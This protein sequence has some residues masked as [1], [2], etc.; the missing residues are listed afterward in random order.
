ML[1]LNLRPIFNAKGIEKPSQFLVKN[2]FNSA[3]AHK[4]LNSKTRAIKLDHIEKLCEILFCE[5]TDLFQ[6][7]PENADAV[8][9]NNP[10]R[11]LIADKENPTNLRNTLINLPYKQLKEISAK[12]SAEIKDIQ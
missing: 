6:W 5:P 8:L 7:I 9:P 11:Q 3:A 10:L 4:L 12:M 1:Y 2:G